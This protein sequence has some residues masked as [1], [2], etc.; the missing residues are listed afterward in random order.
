[1]KDHAPDIGIAVGGT[2]ATAGTDILSAPHWVTAATAGLT[3][4]FVLFKTAIAFL[5]FRRKW[6]HRDENTR[7]WKANESPGDE[8]RG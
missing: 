4:L 1:M 3:M 7:R 8:P 2:L 6:M 5:E